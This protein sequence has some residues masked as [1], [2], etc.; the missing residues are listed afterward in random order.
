MTIAIQCNSSLVFLGLTLFYDG[1]KSGFLSL[2]QGLFFCARAVLQ[3]QII[4]HGVKSYG[5]GSHLEKGL[6]FCFWPFGLKSGV[7]YKTATA[8]PCIYFM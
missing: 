5:N 6:F 4:D 7:L 1:L 2:R 3:S 8:L